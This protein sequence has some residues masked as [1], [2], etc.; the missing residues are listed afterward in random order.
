MTDTDEKHIRAEALRRWRAATEQVRLLRS[1]CNEIEARI[2]E[3]EAIRRASCR[4]L[5]PQGTAL[6]QEK[7]YADQDG[8]R[9][10]FTPLGIFDVS[11][12][13]LG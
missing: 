11:V 1:E 10:M 9:F 7:T 4:V 2:A 13:D 12:E 5:C 3:Q 6:G 8:A